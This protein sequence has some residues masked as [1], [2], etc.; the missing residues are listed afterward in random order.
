MNHKK[1]RNVLLKG[2]LIGRIMLYHQPVGHA[3]LI[4][5]SYS[6]VHAKHHFYCRRLEI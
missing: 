6:A 4:Y 1:A 5:K 2:N 3:A